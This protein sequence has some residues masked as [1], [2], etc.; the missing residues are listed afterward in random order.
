VVEDAAVAVEPRDGDPAQ[1]VEDDPLLR[2]GLE[3]I[4]IRRDAR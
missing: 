2:V 4:P 1:R 3:A